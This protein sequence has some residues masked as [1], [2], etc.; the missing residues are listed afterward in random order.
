LPDIAASQLL[1]YL[2]AMKLRR[3]LLINFGQH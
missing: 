1:S 2:H 3:G